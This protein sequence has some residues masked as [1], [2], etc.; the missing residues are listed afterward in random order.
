M[1]AVLGRGV[2]IAVGPHRCRDTPAGV[3]ERRG[4]RPDA[5]E[6]AVTAALESAIRD[7]M[8]LRGA[9]EIVAPGTIPDNAKKIADVRTW[10]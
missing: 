4:R 8:R 7:V 2:Q 9:V 1:G 3:L 5:D 10:K 6:R